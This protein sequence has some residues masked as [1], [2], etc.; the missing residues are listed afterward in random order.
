MAD[1]EV[2]VVLPAAAAGA[3][4]YFDD[5]G[6]G[7]E[8]IADAEGHVL[9]RPRI[10]T[11]CR[12]AFTFIEVKGA[13]GFRDYR[14]DA[15]LLRAGVD[16]QIRI[17]MPMDPRR[18]GDTWLPPLAPLVQ[19][20]PN[21]LVGP[22]R[23]IR[24]Q[25]AQRFGFE[26]ASG[27][28]NVLFHIWYPAPRIWRDDRDRALRT[29]DT[30]AEA[31]YQG[32]HTMRALGADENRGDDD[33]PWWAGRTVNPAWAID[34]LV[35]LIGAS[36]ERGLG[37]ELSLGHRF[38]RPREDRLDYTTR[39]CEAIHAAGLDEAIRFW[40]GGNEFYQNAEFGVSQ[41]QIDIFKEEFAI[42]KRIL[43]PA[44][45]CANGDAGANEDPDVHDGAGNV[46]P[47]GLRWG[48]KNS[49]LTV[50]HGTRDMPA[51][52]K[53]AFGLWYFE[54]NPGS[55][56]TAFLQ[57][58]PT[59]PGEG[60]SVARCD[61]PGYLAALYGMILLTGQALCAVNGAGIWF[62]RDLDADPWFREIPH[63]LA[64]LPQDV[65]SWD[66]EPGGHIWWWRGPS[67]RYATVTVEG[68]DP[69]PPR[70][71]AAWKVIGPGGG[72][73]EGAGNDAFLRALKPGYH[74]ALVVAEFA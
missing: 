34:A 48:A 20:S 40:I 17:G 67:N 64:E 3:R 60:V 38:V 42:V 61:D 35:G 52:V 70:P 56:P 43:S 7:H 21:A 41:Q 13:P 12:D 10:G 62:R 27:P 53:R 23:V 73:Q 65:A 33:S 8:A 51:A 54:G 36:H 69:T 6:G 39:F 16:R 66:H 9:F 63:W 47:G 28:R 5:V 14:Q 26:D 58:E 31:G 37:V 44:P 18:Y 68:W 74:G 2:L 50:V 49:D 24:H 55:W 25:A 22:L 46:V 1:R 29:L 45:L 4:V 72:I 59:G 30:L 11:D 57:D 19:R 32:I 15:V 71:L